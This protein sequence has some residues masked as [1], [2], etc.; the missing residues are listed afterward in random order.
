MS[1]WSTAIDLMTTPNVPMWAIFVF[2]LIP[3]VIGWPV[4]FVD[5]I[6]RLKDRWAR[7]RR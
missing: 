5:D 2:L 4:A 7:R 3:I 1:G 6:A